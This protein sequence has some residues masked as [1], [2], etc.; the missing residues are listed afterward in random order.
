MGYGFQVYDNYQAGLTG[1][2]IWS[3]GAVNLEGIA[4]AAFHGAVSGSVA[5]VLSPALGGIGQAL[6]RI[7]GVG[8]AL[9]R[10]TGTRLGRMGVTAATEFLIGRAQRVAYNVTTGGLRNW[11]D[12]LW[13]PQSREWR[14]EVA[15]DIVP[16][17]AA[18]GLKPALQAAG[19]GVKAAA[20]LTG[21]AAVRLAGNV[22]DGLARWRLT[23]RLDDYAVRGKPLNPWNRFKDDI[24]FGL[25]T[26]RQSGILPHHAVRLR[27]YSAQHNLTIAFRTTKRA[28]G[29]WNLLGVPA[30]PMGWGLDYTPPIKTSRWGL[31]FDPKNKVTRVIRADYDL[32]AIMGPGGA[33]PGMP[34]RRMYSDSQVASLLPDLDYAVSGIRGGGYAR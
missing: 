17:V 7:P 15:L 12:D 9:S 21:A 34:G 2:D 4:R 27:N 26:F 33:G 11:N 20:G 30:K 29:I 10:A 1:W 3:K 16:G 28:A 5:G 24:Q 32:A 31:A 18:V 8:R 23:Q 13:N 6:G 22:G 25:R 19:R 14:R